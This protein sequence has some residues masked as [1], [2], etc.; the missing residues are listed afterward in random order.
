MPLI[1]LEVDF[2]P[3]DPMSISETHD[4]VVIDVLRATT[5]MITALAAGASSILPCSDVE[6]AR[7]LASAMSPR[8]LLGGERQGR[9]IPGFDLGNSPA[10]YSED[11]VS[12]REIVFTTTN[13]TQCLLACRRARRVLLA[14]FVNLIA[15]VREVSSAP[16]IRLVCAGTDGKVTLEDVWL[17]GELVSYLKARE[18]NHYLAS[19]AA[20]M[21]ASGVEAERGSLWNAGPLARAFRRSQGGRNLIEIGMESDLELAA[22][23]NAFDIVPIWNAASGRVTLCPQ[24]PLP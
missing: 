11:V 7:V 14:G 13:G 17:A 16:G 20:V 10:E 3:P 23:I 8:P 9:K 24:R 6:Q 22:Q 5:T 15:V 19:D 12:G 2:L 1:P 18:P 4:A 21:A